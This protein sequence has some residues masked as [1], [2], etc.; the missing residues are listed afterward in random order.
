MPGFSAQA[1]A[2]TRTISDAGGNWDSPASWA[3]GA[4][5][6]A[7]DDVVASATSGS[8]TINVAAACRSI[9]LSSYPNSSTLTHNA[10]ILSVGDATGGMLNFSGAWT[11][12]TVGDTSAITF[13]STSNN[14][15]SGWPVTT[16]GKVFGHTTFNGPGGKWVLQDDLTLRSP[17]A[18]L[19][20]FKGSLDV[21]NRTITTGYFKSF[22]WQTRTLTSTNSV[23]NVFYTGY[24]AGWYITPNAATHD[25]STTS[26]NVT[27]GTSFAGA[28]YTYK[29]VTITGLQTSASWPTV[30]YGA[31]TFTNFTVNGAANVR[32]YLTF[33]ANQTI[34]GTLTLH[35][36][37]P[38]NRI[39]V[40]SRVGGTAMTLTASNVSVANANFQ[41]ITGA[42]TGNWDLSAVTGLSGDCGGN[43]GIIFTAS[44]TQIWQN[45]N[46]GSWSTAANW[47]SRVPLPQD[48]VVMGTAFNAGKTVQVD[49]P[50]IGRNIDW[51]G[52]TNPPAWGG[53]M[54]SAMIHGSLTLIPGM[55]VGNFISFQFVGRAASTFTT[56]G[57]GLTGGNLSIY[58]VGGTLTLQDDITLTAG[59]ITLG[60]GH[61]DTNNKNVTATSFGS[62]GSYPRTLTMGS[63]TW[64]LTGTGTVWD[65]TTS[66]NLTF[67]A[68]SST[69]AITNSSASAKT[70]AGGGLAY[71]NLTIAGGGTG[72][73]IFTGSNTFNNVTIGSPKTVTFT[74]GT[75]QTIL[76]N[77]TALGSAGNLIT[78]N[79]STPGSI[80]TLAMAS[81][82][83]NA[84]YL[85]I[86]DVSVSGGAVWYAGAN[87]SYAG[88][89]IGTGWIFTSA[90]VFYS[91]GQSAAD[92][93]VAATLTIAAGIG[94]FSAAQ[95]GNIGVGDRVTY[96]QIDIT[97]FA[98]QG[99]GL[100]RITT[101][102]DHGFQRY[103]YVNISGTTSYNGTYQI[104]NVATA[105]S[106]DIVKAYMA[107][108]GGTTKYVANIAQIS[109]KIS[110]TVWSLITPRGGT[111]SARVSAVTVNSIR[112][113][114]TSL[115]AAVGGAK[116]ANHLNSSD[117]IAA[118]LVLNIPCY[119]DTGADTTAVTVS[120]YTTGASNYI[121]IYTPYNTATETNNS[122]RHLGT[123]DNTKY[124]LEKTNS[125]LVV[126]TV[127]YVRY[128]GLQL[129]LT[130]NNGTNY[131]GF[132]IGATSDSVVTDI[133]ITANIIQ[134][135][136][137]STGQRSAVQTWR[138][139]GFS[140]N[141]VKVHN[142]IIYGF[143]NVSY[144]SAVRVRYATYFVYNN[145][146]K[147]CYWGIL[148]EA[149]TV[150][151]KNNIIQ[152]TVD[153]FNGTF[154]GTSNY[155]ISDL[156]ADAPGANSKNSTT[157]AF[158]D[159]VNK[160]F[161]LAESDSAARDAGTNLSADANLAFNTDIDGQTRPIGA[162][163]DI[164]ADE[165]SLST[166]PIS[167]ITVP[168]NAA[169]IN[170]ASPA[171]YTISGSAT[172]NVAVTGIEVSTDNG[173]SWNA[174][175]CSGCPGASVT[176]TYSWTVPADASY[177][178]RSRAT[179][180]LANL[181]S[182]AAGN[183]VIVD[184]TSPTISS[185][186]PA[187]LATGVA[188]NSSVTINWAENI[189]CSTVNTATI[190]ISGGGWTLS[191][192]SGSQAVFDTSGQFGVTSYTVT[193][194]TAVMDIHANAMTAPYVFSYTTVTPAA[195]YY[196]V[197]QSAADLKTGSPTVTISGG[198]A[199]FSVAQ[200]GNI[201]VGDRVTYNTSNIAYIAA[202]SGA[203]QKH[204]RL[205]TATG[206]VPPDIAGS[207]VVSIR[208][209]YMSLSAAVGG[210]K[211]ASHLNSSD[212]RATNTI[213]NIPC[214]YDTGADT[215]AVI[216]TGY[217][218]GASNYIKIYTP[219]NTATEANNSQRHQG[220]WNDTKYN[221]KY[222]TTPGVSNVLAIAISNVRVDGLQIKGT[223]GS[224]IGLVAIKVESS[225]ANNTTSISNCIV[226]GVSSTSQNEGIWVYSSIKAWNNIIYGFNLNSG[227]GIRFSVSTANISYISNVTIYDCVYGLNNTW[228][229]APLAKNVITQN[230]T[231]GFNGAINAGS[232]YNIS[233]K[234]A[235]ASGAN[236]KNATTVTFVDAANKD[237]H[238]SN[239]DTAA[240]GSG[241]NLSA[242]PNLPFSTDIDGQPRPTGAWDIGA[243]QVFGALKIKGNVKVNGGVRIKKY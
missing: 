122:Q 158:V 53:V 213:L 109:G 124:R 11:Y 2:A 31:N 139:S 196:S 12:T 69:I 238:L 37:S 43:S 73:V 206:G 171:P 67:N 112:H 240:R 19:E 198:A 220:K 86:M 145:T 47:T 24:S 164:G 138:P 160:D 39:L 201:G 223:A 6:T 27:A 243:D 3:E 41:D 161:H 153:G 22:S 227:S 70:F 224:G 42:G 81:G 204:W 15:G 71:N 61:L 40:M 118:N 242:D 10:F 4:V 33:D 49:M 176:W 54:A 239:S 30:V 102:G 230:C 120:G 91:V 236:S 168:A 117:L 166:P 48:D 113:E 127:N 209:E 219:Y 44:A 205:V 208:H 229:G 100:T 25:F 137:T 45:P 132:S 189:D 107:E 23:F 83:V 66:T 51:S 114:Y 184:R 108:A 104:S 175:T 241:I 92:L 214:Y 218:T 234:P 9:D 187:N 95:T 85:S 64:T 26:V 8:L 55:T 136:L 56:A 35:G 110:Q 159:A 32:G 173:G 21:S 84:S 82:R 58:M 99:G 178:I 150:T 29:N 202:K 144:S 154:A 143:D 163:W 57:I 215:A 101:S 210:A 93:K 180:S 142:N 18:I 235:D 115:S 106:L 94:T 78:L 167:A 181:E 14:G 129:K 60:I 59:G 182:P 194:S 130:A 89:N 185:S 134:G 98:D 203:D 188:R 63:G 152:N 123:W 80:A 170:L 151:A 193:V 190:T 135:I 125:D 148:Q 221:L 96:G 147:N 169:I 87:S 141:V 36:D 90:P 52:A 233:N 77:L 105:T 1:S 128:E 237:F 68:N 212:L 88:G 38:T 13:A 140:V 17:T 222:T 28:G 183:T 65:T 126:T 162:A 200:T 75:T 7:A 165:A 146:I 186:T 197:G 195:V 131:A 228:V 16:G 172:D 62:S 119:Y 74:S 231:D 179:D 46:G 111:P 191:S 133:R 50:D 199:V 155:N 97:A 79:S 103:D 121:K 20:L 5:P 156:A 207:T 116:D 157:V 177:T 226:S 34:S 174:A 149:G 211:D 225:V 232:N 72:A 217:T 192:C 76:G 216:V